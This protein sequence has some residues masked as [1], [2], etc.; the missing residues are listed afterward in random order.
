M[1]YARGIIFFQAEDGIRDIGVTGVQTC[2]LPIY[3]SPGARFDLAVGTAELLYFRRIHRARGL[4]R[5]IRWPPAHSTRLGSNLDPRM[6]RTGGRSA[7]LVVLVADVEL[8]YDAG[9]EVV[10]EP[11]LVQG[12]VLDVDVQEHKAG[13]P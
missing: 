7:D 8:E 4:P 1:V 12:E 6:P 3:I 11:G 9:A 13:S 2:A 10:D 5:L